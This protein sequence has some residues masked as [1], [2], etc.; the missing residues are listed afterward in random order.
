MSGFG[1][2]NEDPGAG[3]GTININNTIIAGNTS[4]GN[5]SD[6]RGAFVSGG[7][8]LIGDADGSTGFANGVNNDIVGSETGSGVV[9]AMLAPL[10]DNGG[11]I[12]TCALLLG[13]P[14]INAGD[15]TATTDQRGVARPSG[16][17]ADGIPGP[18]SIGAFELSGP[19]TAAQDWQLHE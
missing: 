11:P 10:A 4:S 13:S 3:V 1:I 8:N 16:G 2:D 17:V 5:S 6:V 7:F 9:D 12:Q 19:P 15:S 14:A 18:D